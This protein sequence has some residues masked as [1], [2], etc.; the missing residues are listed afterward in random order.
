MIAVLDS[1]PPAMGAALAGLLGLVLGSF[2]AALVQRWG[3]G[4]SILHPPSQ[5]DM[6]GAKLTIRDLVP[7]LSWL[8]LRGR[9]RH[10][11]APIPRFSA[12]IELASLLIGT[13][14]LALVPGTHGW[15]LAMFG[16]MLLPLALLDARH[17]WLPDTLIA[18]LAGTA[19]LLGLFGVEPAP[20]D[21][22]I[23]AAAG[24]LTL[25][26]IAAAYRRA[27]GRE[28]M[29]GGD[30]KFMAAI[31]CWLGWQL[32]PLVL[33]LASLTGLAWAMIS[34]LRG[35]TAAPSLALRAVPFGTFLALAAFAVAA[36]QAATGGVLLIP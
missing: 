19:M 20:L 10:C 2:I 4:R 29:G 9:C 34:G 1:A 24:G 32:L 15:L 30:P 14:S 17:L 27:R 28:G 8:A 11:G 23:G 22:L 33:L 35:G 25:A 26:L 3:E 31:G 16:W 36:L 12:E 21:R 13:C 18:L 7:L 6:C 5:C